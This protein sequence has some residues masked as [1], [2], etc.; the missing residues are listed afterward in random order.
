MVYL[1]LKLL[2]LVILLLPLAGALWIF[3]RKRW[4]RAPSSDCLL[5]A[6][7]CLPLLLIGEIIT[8][9][10]IPF[11]HP[12]RILWLTQLLLSGLAV[13]IIYKQ[14]AT[15]LTV[16]R[17]A[18][19]GAADG[20]RTASWVQRSALAVG[21][22][23]QLT[24][25][26]FGA[27][28]APWPWDEFSYHIPQAVQPYQDGRLGPVQANLTAA[29]SYPRGAELLF[30]WTLQL[31]HSDAGF[32]PVN[33][34][35]GFVFILATYVAAM[36]LGLGRG[37]AWLAAGIVP[38][39]PIFWYLGTIGYID[40]SVAGA[41]AAFAALALPERDRP[42]SWGSCVA[43]LLAGILAMWMKF[44]PVLVLGLIG[45]CRVLLTVGQWALAVLRGAARPRPGPAPLIAA[46][47]LAASLAAIPYVRSWAK[48]GNPIFP[49]K[50]SIGSRVLFDGEVGVGDIGG[51]YSMP[52]LQRYS[53]YWCG[54]WYTPLSPDSPGSLGP[55]FSLAMLAAVL[56][57][58]LG[59]L[60]LRR[61]G[62]LMVIASFWLF[63]FAPQY[64]LN[65]YSLYI[66]L[67]AALCIARLGK[68]LISAELGG[69]WAFAV[70]LLAGVNLH[71]LGTQLYEGIRWQKSV[72]LPLLTEARN[73]PLVDRLQHSGPT[74]PTPETRRELYRLMRDGETLVT[75]VDGLQGLFY[76]YKYRYRVEHRPARPWPVRRRGLD[77]NH[78]AA[79]APAWLASLQRDRVEAAMVYADSAEDSVLQPANSGYHLVYEQPPEK[80]GRAF[81]IYRRSGL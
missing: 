47:L 51:A 35:F 29:D 72:G 30:Y 38:T 40:L 44:T 2:G 3:W 65:R 53:T 6:A 75:A 32:H 80:E 10:S 54:W 42:W 73:R 31:T 55:L 64:H 41:V 69:S 25:L 8:L 1:S 58:S 68:A 66:L 74:E 60:R 13:W 37:W 67:P 49:V 19:S 59:E 52:L 78:G 14:R 81:R 4:E 50:V 18:A 9:G 61:R 77:L 36:R 20:W 24:S 22:L 21:L 48:Y 34:T 63:V 11:G 17:Q 79:E 76:D 39:T 46:S 43:M 12:L 26:V 57:C 16:L 7:V 15:F 56:I 70:L 28:S 62:W 5:A 23:T 45:T 33:A 71:V 27:W